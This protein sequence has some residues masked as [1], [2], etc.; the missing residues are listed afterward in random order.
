[1]QHVPAQTHR[2]EEDREREGLSSGPTG[3][4]LA[5]E[6]TAI[7]WGR[8]WTGA[9]PGVGVLEGWGGHMLRSQRKGQGS[10]WPCPQEPQSEGETGPLT[11]GDPQTNGRRKGSK[12]H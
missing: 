8:K 1:M 5:W 6:R 11:S 7:F 2:Q 3:S 10:S 4:I 12:L 9:L